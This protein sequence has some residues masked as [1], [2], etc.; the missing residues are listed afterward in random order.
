MADV[1]LADRTAQKPAETKVSST[2]QRDSPAT[3]AQ[4]TE[5]QASANRE[6]NSNE[7]D[8]ASARGAHLEADLPARP[9][10]PA[11]P[12]ASQAASKISDSGRPANVPKRP[13]PERAPSGAQN[14]RAQAQGPHRFN[15]EDKL[16]PRPDLL[17]DRRDRHQDYPRGGRFGGDHD[18]SRPF[19][20]AM[21]DG[22]P[23]PRGDRDYPRQ[24]MDEPFR[25]FPHRDG[26]PARDADWP[27]RSGRLR[28]DAREGPPNVRSVPPTHPDRAGMIDDHPE[29]FRRG[30]TGRQDRDDRRNLQQRALSPP[31]MEPLGRPERFPADDRRGANFAHPHARNE[32]M[33]TGPRSERYGRPSMDGADSR[34]TVTGIDMNHGRLRQPEPPT[35]VPSGPRG[36]NNAGRG[37]RNVPGSQHSQGQ[38]AAGAMAPTERQPPTGPGRQGLRNAPDQPAPTGPSSPGPEKL[39]T[40]GIHPDRL[41]VLQQQPQENT[42]GGGQ[43]PHHGSSPASIVPPSGPRSGLGPPSGPAAM[44]RGPPSGPGFGG[45][46]GRGDK[47]FAGINNMLQQSGG[48]PDRGPGP[49]IR[50]RGANRQSGAMNAPSPQ[51]ARPPTPVAQEEGGRGGPASQGRPDLMAGRSSGAPYGEEDGHP[52]SRPGGSRGEP[53]EES[54][55][56]SRRSQRF[57]S[58]TYPERERER[59]R[60]RERRGGDEEGSRSSSRREEHRD[61]NRDYERE[62]S[63]RSD[64]GGAPGGPREERYESREASRRGPGAREDNR[65]RRDREEGS[66]IAPSSQEHE[67]RLRPPSSLGGQGPPPPPPPPLAAGE[68]DRRWGGGRELRDRERD[69][70]RDRPRE[71]DYHREGAPSGPHRKRNRPGDEGGHGD[72]GGRG[73]MRMGS[74]SKRPRRGA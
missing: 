65:R 41:K 48:L 5:I 38:P 10:A 57:S 19:D 1:P 13:E 36:R 21:G 72:G 59:E 3:S 46:R 34:D 35:D 52:R 22:R 50:G 60:D 18:Y 67:G 51:S 68:D 61:R 25:G 16:P 30:E 64:A 20:P 37:G 24:P 70:N 7:K 23:Y 44:P 71:R 74:E 33:P 40:S 53:A 73:G 66:D 31:R 12:A 45:E 11:S 58:G 54:S 29:G 9:Q 47:R 14:A 49:T 8:V 69:R 62:R 27:D 32:D 6:Q 4:G 63:R 39:D 56:E 42:Y 26:R 2:S 28:P 15:R 43:R 17:E 55:A